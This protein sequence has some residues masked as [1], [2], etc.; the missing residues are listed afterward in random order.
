MDAS[1]SKPFVMH[2][3]GSVGVWV[4]QHDIHQGTSALSKLAGA[5]QVADAAGAAAA[6]IPG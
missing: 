2:R 5:G 6:A 3:N 1:A 4:D